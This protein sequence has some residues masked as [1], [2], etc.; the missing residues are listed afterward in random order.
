MRNVL[1]EYGYTDEMITRKI[2][3][4]WKHI[5]E[6]EATK[7]Y[8]ECDNKAFMMDTGNVDSRSEGMSYGMMMAVQM[9]RKDIF[10]KL[11]L[12]SMTYMYQ[13]S[14]PFEGYFAWS[15]QPDGTKNS[16]GPAPDGEEYFALALFFASNLWGDGAP[17]FDYSHQAKEIIRAMIHKGEQPDTGAP[18]FNRDNKLI[19]FVAGS[20]FSDPSYHL[21]HF[22]ELIAK[23]C[24]PEDREF[25]LDA[26]RASR[27]YLP[28]ACHPVTGLASDYANFDGSPVEID[29]R[30]I[31]RAHYSDSYRVALNI[32]IDALWS[33]VV[34]AWNRETA[35]KIQ[36][37][38]LSRPDAMADTV[39]YIDGTVYDEE[40][41]H[42]LGLLATAAAASAAREVNPE[43]EKLIKAFMEADMRVCERRY[44]DNCLYFFS[45]LGLGGR[46]RVI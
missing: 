40:I 15:C 12:W 43:S 18:M 44:Y 26:A 25:M 11:W 13:K 16:E 46:F 6:D 14:G 22:Y 45:L 10:D 36:R 42:P 37:F 7:F 35:G 4:A 34:R 32:G 2:D 9:N 38:Y 24:Y 20:E 23:W 31:A 39:V 33:K 17:P 19:L 30:H 5:F 28:T 3:D 29:R 27:E 8:H 21:P 41:M 1:K